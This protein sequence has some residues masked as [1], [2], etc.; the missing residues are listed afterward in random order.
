MLK[1]KRLWFIWYYERSEAYMFA[2]R[3]IDDAVKGNSH[4]MGIEF[5]LR[6]SG[7]DAEA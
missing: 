2:P 5:A 6:D 7:D 4:E 3:I 1:L